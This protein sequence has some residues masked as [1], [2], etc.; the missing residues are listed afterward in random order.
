[1]ST[2]RFIVKVPLEI[3]ARDYRRLESSFEVGR[4]I[5]NAFLREADK[6]R[7]AYESNNNYQLARGVRGDKE[8]ERELY[9]RAEIESGYYFRSASK[10]S[11]NNSLEQFLHQGILGKSFLTEHFG[12]HEATNLC[13]RAFESSRK[14]AFHKAKR[15]HY[16]KKRDKIQSVAGTSM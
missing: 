2:S 15:V 14:V 12:R 1:M 5:Y 16:K 11:R 10:Y 4:L 7:I 13:K 3:S 9:G 6:R 8:K